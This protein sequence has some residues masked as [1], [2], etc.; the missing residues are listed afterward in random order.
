MTYSSIEQP[1][2]GLKYSAEV[3]LV[4]SIF[5]T[6]SGDQAKRE[7]IMEVLKNL[8]GIY[9]RASYWSKGETTR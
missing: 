8:R 1:P 4:E 7:H 6:P 5:D 2:Q 9:I 3:T